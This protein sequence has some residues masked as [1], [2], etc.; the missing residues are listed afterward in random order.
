MRFAKKE[1]EITRPETSI[2]DFV[3]L[4]NADA[5]TILRRCKGIGGIAIKPYLAHHS[6]ICGVQK[7]K[8]RWAIVTGDS[9]RVIAKRIRS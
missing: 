1:W 2:A 3:Q 4:A 8:E 9:Y 5:R 7:I 6:Y